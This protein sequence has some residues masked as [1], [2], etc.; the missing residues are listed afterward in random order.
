MYA[1]VINGLELSYSII[2]AG[3]LK[4]ALLRILTVADKDEAELSMS[5]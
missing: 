5:D 2:S 3:Y 1:L 4:R